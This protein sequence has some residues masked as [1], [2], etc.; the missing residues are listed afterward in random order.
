MA[1]KNKHIYVYII[2]GVSM[3]VI[4]VLIWGFAT[5]WKFFGSDDNNNQKLQSALNKLTKSYQDA[6]EK[7]ENL[8]D[9]LRQKKE[10][11]TELSKLKTDVSL[12][13]DKKLQKISKL[14]QKI[15]DKNKEI[16]DKNKEIERV[17][18]NTKNQVNTVKIQ[19][20]Q[21][22]QGI[23]N[24]ELAKAEA[25]KK[26]KEAEQKIGVLELEKAEESKKLETAKEEI[27]K[28]EL[29]KAEES[30][31]LETAKEEIKKLELAQA[32]ASKNLKEAQ[33]K[34]EKLR[35]TNAILESETISLK[36]QLVGKQS[37]FDKREKELL[38]T[39]RDYLRETDKL[40]LQKL[41]SQTPNKEA[42]ECYSV[43]LN[44]L[45]G[46]CHGENKKLLNDIM[47]CRRDKKWYKSYYV[48]NGD[49]KSLGD[50]PDFCPHQIWKYVK[51]KT[52]ITDSQKE[53]FNKHA[54]KSDYTNKYYV[55]CNKWKYI[56]NFS[57]VDFDI[58]L[59][60]KDQTQNCDTIT[61]NLKSTEWTYIQPKSGTK[62]QD[63]LSA[64]A[65]DSRSYPKYYYIYCDKFEN[66]RD[67]AT[68][69][70]SNKAEPGYVRTCDDCRSEEKVPNFYGSETCARVALAKGYS[71]FTIKDSNNQCYLEQPC[72]DSNLKNFGKV[73]YSNYVLEEDTTNCISK[74]RK[75]AKSKNKDSNENLSNDVLSKCFNLG[76]DLLI[77][78]SVNSDHTKPALAA[79]NFNKDNPFP[80]WNDTFRITNLRRNDNLYLHLF[81]IDTTKKT[82]TDYKIYNS[83]DRYVTT[84]KIS[85]EEIK[86]SN[87][88]TNDFLTVTEN[89]GGTDAI[90]GCGQI[91]FNYRSFLQCNN[92]PRIVPN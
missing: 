78:I 36:A 35:N 72:K 27:K 24:L 87:N 29:E 44:I 69:V 25:S 53:I 85:F 31:K 81:E 14:E 15:E 86:N 60:G 82:T 48:K 3:L 4:G 73:G 65:T 17:T 7:L 51:P 12:S 42:D 59:S 38:G 46:E 2:I 66:V 37:K 67:I 54:K 21:V 32:D 62:R 92:P 40:K 49:G 56:K 76:D 83:R 58:P 16:E 80:V 84:K 88:L 6:K 47:K 52:S 45:K 19:L 34:I 70:Q 28:L 74:T 1:K 13:G 9:I 8:N 39:I 63:M 71:G 18:I 41:N 55:W 26:L 20:T 11:E 77:K 43:V 91:S 22:R 30:K 61:N 64:G 89:C 10:L 68:V 50:C 79:T 23:K 5:K 33:A 75:Y 57:D 90:T